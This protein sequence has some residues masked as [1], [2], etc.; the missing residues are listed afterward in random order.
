MTGVALNVGLVSLV[1][2]GVL[3]LLLVAMHVGH[4]Y[5]GGLLMSEH[6]TSTQAAEVLALLCNSPE[7]RSR[8]VQ[9]GGVLERL[10]TMTGEES[11][12]KTVALRALLR[13]ADDASG[14]YGTTWWTAA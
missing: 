5:L 13:L 14:M 12:A 1:L 6:S 11:A 2:L 9:R 10:L 8:V 3:A 7:G 4:L